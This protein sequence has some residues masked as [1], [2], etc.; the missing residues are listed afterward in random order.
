[1]YLLCGPAFPLLGIYQREKKHVLTQRK[2]KEGVLLVRAKNC[3]TQRG[4]SCGVFIQWNMQSNKK[5][6][7]LIHE[8][9]E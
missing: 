1:M 9:L 3:T 7:L 5:N 2:K 6:K 4:K 8:Q